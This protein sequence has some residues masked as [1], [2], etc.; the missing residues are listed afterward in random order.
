[1]SEL[2]GQVALVTGSTRGIGRAVAVA[3]AGAGAKVAVHGRNEAEAI[4]VAATIEGAT[5]YG[6]DMGDRAAVADLVARVSGELGPI[7]VLVNNAGIADRSAITRITDEEWDRT[8]AVNLTGPLA[9]IRAVVPAMKKGGG[10]SI[11]N[12]IS[13]AATEGSAGFGGYAASKGGLLGLTMTLAAE[14]AMFNIRVNAVSPA[15][16]TG[17]TEQLPPDLLQVMID[18]NLPSVDSVAETIF[19]LCSPRSRD[20]TGQVLKI[21]GGLTKPAA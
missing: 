5:G 4:A 10:G 7:D 9:A 21:L 12:L 19:F 11:V 13:G 6:A 15:A 18:R 1:M 3:L 17:M 16:L 8:I 14:L 2:T 20:M